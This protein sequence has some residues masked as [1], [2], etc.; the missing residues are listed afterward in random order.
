MLNKERRP[1]L[2]SLYNTVFSIGE[3]KKLNFDGLVKKARNN[4]GHGNLGPDF[5]DD[6]LKILIKS[7][8][9][10][11]GLHP[12]GQLMIREKLIS[13]IENRLWAEY[14][15]HKYPEILKQDVLPIV[16]VTGLQRTGTTKMQRL[17]SEQ[18]GAR[19]LMSWEAL[20]P[21]P[22]GNKNETK[23]RIARTKRNERAVRWISPTFHTIHPIHTHK[24]EEDV[25]LL[26][27]HFMSTS[28]EAIMHVPTY[29]NWLSKQDA[30]EAYRYEKKLLQLLQWQRSGGFWVIKSPHHLLHLENFLSVFPKTKV[31]WMH[32]QPEQCVPSFLSMLYYSRSM[33]VKD[34]DK[35]LIKAHW[36]PKIKAMLRSGIEFDARHPDRILDV[37]FSDF[38]QMERSVL[39]DVH[40]FIKENRKK[41]GAMNNT[42]HKSFQSKHRYTLMDWGLNPHMIQQE[43]DFYN[44]AFFKSAETSEYSEQR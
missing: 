28:S 33:F 2:I 43:F 12:F 42:Y 4:T 21:A 20:Y 16:L 6:S 26:D 36:L 7:I 22:I 3:G 8:N 44:K 1:L 25:L 11:A 17:L 23:K 13:Q 34:V 29:A 19:G 32:R 5:N 9:E 37:Y 38:M 40:A 30:T 15:F 18:A 14:W 39:G 27:V 41:N 31:I 10:E 35:D 24:P